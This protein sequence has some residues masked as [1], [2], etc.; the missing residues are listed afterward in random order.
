[1]RNTSPL[2]VCLLLGFLF[3]FE[4]YGNPVQKFFKKDL[5]ANDG[6][7]PGAAIFSS[8]TAFST[9]LGSSVNATF[10]P[11]KP[12]SMTSQLSGCKG[13]PK[14]FIAVEEQEIIYFIASQYEQLMFEIAMAEG[15]TLNTFT[16]M[17]KVSKVHQKKFQKTLKNN[18]DSIYASS[19][20]SAKEIYK[21]VVDLIEK[22]NFLEG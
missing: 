6:C 1:M 4:T 10:S 9:V 16:K 19:Q 17:F 8:D 18:Y 2:R 15:E 21:S 12:S 22:N 20:Q 3:A 5:P 7:G 14:N 13:G 11:L